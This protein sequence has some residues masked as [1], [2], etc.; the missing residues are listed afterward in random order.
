M[1]ELIQPGMVPLV[2]DV[3]H[4]WIRRAHLLNIFGRG[5]GTQIRVRIPC[6]NAALRPIDF[7][8]RS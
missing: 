8:Q 6:S 5:E 3:I 2:P 1:L 4:A 7:A